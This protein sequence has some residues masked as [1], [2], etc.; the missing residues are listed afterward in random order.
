MRDHPRIVLA[1]RNRVRAI[2]AGSA[3]VAAMF[4]FGCGYG[5]AQ[6]AATMPSAGAA[7]PPAV[8]TLSPDQI[9]A[10]ASPSVFVVESSD[11]GDINKRM[12]T[13]F[14]VS[15]DGLVLTNFHVIR[16]AAEVTVKSPDD[17]AHYPVS[18]VVAID[19]FGDLALLKTALRGKPLEIA[20]ETA[21]AIG[22]RVYAIGNPE[23]LTLTLSEGLISAIRGKNA[24]F[25]MLQISVPI[26]HGS[27]GG[28]LFSS[29]GKVV[30]VTTLTMAEGQNLNF[31]VPA[32]TIRRILDKSDNPPAPVSVAAAPTK[33]QD[34]LELS[35]AW[36]QALGNDYKSS[37]LLLK[38]I[39]LRQEKNSFYWFLT[40]YLTEHAQVYKSAISDYRNALKFSPQ[41]PATIY[42]RLG[43]CLRAQAKYTEAVDAFRSCLK[44]EPDNIGAWQ[45][46]AATFN[47]MG[48]P[49]KAI[50]VIE[51]S[52]HLDPSDPMWYSIEGNCYLS[53]R[54]YS[55]AVDSFEKL[56]EI[57]P[58][59]PLTWIL[60]GGA[61]HHANND[62]AARADWEKASQLD[63]DGAL[64][65]MARQNIQKMDD[66]SAFASSD[67]NR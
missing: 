5:V 60:L 38:D 11:A 39:G 26:S 67:P 51:K 6:T 4:L 42:L 16:G 24:F 17:G 29:D 48:Q 23:G 40:G 1:K 45:S 66:T 49:Q 19:R 56:S 55:K 22:S 27:S 32:S 33:F 46:A 41:Y 58:A 12:G 35:E 50:G 36:V 34:E 61:H 25:P 44:Y 64:G 20:S 43:V 65:S 8:R 53:I 15:S 52:I 10:A 7:A 57:R 62:K 13:G 2:C 14:L 37:Y 59:E 18:G 9:F 47:M 21:P 63:P 54:Q 28:P 30:G 31:A 3:F